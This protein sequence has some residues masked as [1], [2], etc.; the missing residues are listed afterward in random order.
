MRALVLGQRFC[1]SKRRGL[2][3]AIGDL[4]GSRKDSAEPQARENVHVVALPRVQRLP[5]EN[6]FRERRSRGKEHSAVCVLDGVLIRA[7]RKAD[8]VGQWEDDWTGVDIGHEGDDLR[9]EGSL[10]QC[11]DG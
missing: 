5:I 1:Q 4:C 11:P 8:R 3:H 2:D 9:C 7:F 10:L 6:L